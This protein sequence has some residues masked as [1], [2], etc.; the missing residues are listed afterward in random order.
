M[1]EVLFNLGRMTQIKMEEKEQKA[2]DFLKSQ[3]TA[4]LWLPA[5]Y[6]AGASE[7][8]LNGLF[9]IRW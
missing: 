7:P 4:L 1:R 9:I 5:N 3:V 8:P 2:K 6:C